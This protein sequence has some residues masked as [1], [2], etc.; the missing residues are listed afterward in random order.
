MRRGARLP[1]MDSIPPFARRYCI[2]C[3]S[4]SGAHPKYRQLA[5]RT[6]RTLARDGI[7]VVYGGANRGLMGVVADA[8]LAEGRPILIEVSAPWCSVCRA[9]KAVLAELFADPRYARIV[10]LDIDFDSQVE[11]VRAF[12]AQRQSTL[13]LFAGGREIAR[14][15]GDASRAGIMAMLEAAL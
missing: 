12:G 15:V 10:A 3:G 8:A 1:P 5:E 11:A 14:S 13:I 2:F 7:G 6:G 9:Q 4:S